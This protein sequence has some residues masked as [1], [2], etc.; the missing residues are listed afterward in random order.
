MGPN[1]P[2]KKG[3][4]ITPSSDPNRNVQD[5]RARARTHRVQKQDA[6]RDREQEVD[7]DEAKAVAMT[8]KRKSKRNPLAPKGV[9]KRT[10][11][12]GFSPRRKNQTEI[13]DLSAI[14]H[15][16]KGADMRRRS[17]RLKKSHK[18][19]SRHSRESSSTRAGRRSSRSVDAI[20]EQSEDDEPL[21]QLNE[22]EPVEE[23][24][25]GAVGGDDPD[26][27]DEPD[28]HD[29]DPDDHD[30][31]SDEDDED[32][33]DEDEVEDEKASAFL[34]IRQLKRQLKRMSRELRR[35]SSVSVPNHEHLE[36]ARR[37]LS[38]ELERE[39][40][41]KL[42][43][44]RKS[45]DES[46]G[47]LDYHQRDTRKQLVEM[48]GQKIFQ[49]CTYQQSRELSEMAT[50]AKSVY[51]LLEP[52]ER[53]RRRDREFMTDRRD[54]QKELIAYNEKLAAESDLVMWFSRFDDW[55][56]KLRI[57]HEARYVKVTTRLLNQVQAD[58]LLQHN[59]GSCAED[60][61]DS[62][63]KLKKWL[64][65]QYDSK[66][67][68]TRAKHRLLQWA[69]P[70]GA[71]LTKA[72]RAYM[73]LIQKYCH[74]IRFALDYG[75]NLN[76]I[77]NPPEGDLFSTFING[78]PHSI[79]RQRVWQMFQ[80]VGGPKRMDILRPICARVDDA[81]RPGLGV[82][83]FVTRPRADLRVMETEPHTDAEHDE[84]YAMR[85]PNRRFT[86]NRSTFRRSSTKPKKQCSLHGECAH[87]TAECWELKQRR[88]EANIMGR[89]PAPYQT[90][91]KP[92]NDRASNS[93]CPHCEKKGMRKHHTADRCWTLHP[94]QFEEFKRQKRGYDR[95]NSKKGRKGSNEEFMAIQVQSMKELEEE[96]EEEELMKMYESVHDRFY[97]ERDAVEHISQ[98]E[99]G[100]DLQEADE[101]REQVMACETSYH[102]TA[103]PRI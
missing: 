92:S 91:S 34:E 75:E 15:R 12:T 49:G 45:H 14:L 28:D 41:G 25:N 84:V 81:L 47:Q 31:D 18:L 44:L 26:D 6:S 4:E 50:K 51:Q 73:G 72:Y 20:Y 102:Y 64:Y 99:D 32:S 11:L 48:R 67:A 93:F 46:L 43:A 27:P 1:H 5:V 100:V 2:P 82:D 3:S 94:E 21:Q 55:A 56:D 97:A 103:P 19:R 76:Q 63:V 60:R 98:D 96:H 13:D 86:R 77:V 52:A 58:E 38:E 42:D 83:D 24:H 57:P 9:K 66:R 70:K 29:S 68:I 8:P 89:A 36:H 39:F 10:S 22:E 95:W 7:D 61:V 88:H 17:A 69:H 87:T 16:A 80:D 62:Y 79:E 90:S 101:P 33:E 85:G 35:I 30:D 53:S 74:E 40:T 23:D 54:Y 65:T 59:D 78:I 71:T 37:A